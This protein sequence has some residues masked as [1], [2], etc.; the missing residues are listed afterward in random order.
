MITAV[1]IN[2]TP[3]RTVRAKV[4]LY[5][6]ST[7]AHTYRYN[8]DLISCEIERLGEESKFF[9][10]G[11]IQKVIVKIKD[12]NRT[13]NITKEHSLKLYIGANDEEIDF[14][15]NQPYFPTFYVEEVQRDENNNDLTITAYDKLYQAANHKVS[16]AYL[17]EAYS[18]ETAVGMLA[19]SLLD[20]TLDREG[21][22]N[23]DF[24]YDNGANFEGTETLQEVFAAAAEASQTFYF[25]KD[26]RLVFKQ[27][28]FG[29]EP[30]LTIDKETYF[31]LKSE[32]SR[33]LTAIAHA[34]ELGDNLITGDPDAGETQYMRDNPFLE[35]REELAWELE[36]IFEQI[37]G[38]ATITPFTCSWR[39]NYLLE[40]GDKIALVTKD[41]NII[42]SYV[43]NDKM[44]YNGGLYAATSWKYEPKERE[45]ADNPT[46]LGEAL[47]YTFAKVDKANK[48]IDIVASES[49][50]NKDAISSL[51]INTAGI[52]A[53]VKEV[54]ENTEKAL[55]G[56][57]E[58]VGQLTEQVS[59][60]MTSEQVKVEIQAQLEDGVN[61]VKTGKGFTFNDNGMTIE[62]I[63]NETNNA[64]KTTISNNGMTV[65]GNNQEKLKANDAGV[66]ATDLHARTYLIIGTNS[67]FENYGTNRTGC[68]WIG[69]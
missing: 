61:S 26:N 63:N 52:S 60:S 59:L 6:G 17:P 39:G 55:Q 69:G 3:V 9:G 23:F 49:K 35:L 19:S 21:A 7:L 67:R 15:T 18:M 24:Y 8:D 16:E 42:T 36:A 29:G 11:I 14:N 64:V 5:N 34:T 13:S 12:V 37:N 10:F 1:E 25:V 56:L 22:A 27:L 48:Q 33:E 65:Y 20:L 62:D 51:Q 44:T 66:V 57:E 47:K 40:P 28:D 38:I 30:V 4:E 50:A 43:I 45:T 41:D 58:S 54:E 68:F 46:S 53:T 31:E 2:N 32:A